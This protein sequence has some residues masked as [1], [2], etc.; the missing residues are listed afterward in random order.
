[1]DEFYMNI[2]IECAKNGI[3]RVQANPLIG[4]VIVKDNK[5]I[6]KD[7]YENTDKIN[8]IEK[9]ILNNNI[10]DMQLNKSTIYITYPDF[11]EDTI[12]YIETKNFSRIVSGTLNPEV[13]LMS[14]KVAKICGLGLQVKVGILENECNNLNEIYNNQFINNRPFVHVKWC[15]T[16]DGKAASYIGNNLDITT[17]KCYAYSHE[18]RNK[19]TAVMVGINTILRDDPTLVC[20]HPGG[21]NS[22]RIIVDSKLR[23]QMDCNVL[24]DAYNTPTFIAVTHNYDK[25]KA[26]ILQTRGVR[27]II[28]EEI[29]GKI[30]L[31][32]L[33]VKLSELNIDSVLIEGG[34]NLIFSAVEDGIVDKVSVFIGAK[35][36]GGK[37]SLSPVTGN[38]IDFMKSGIPL[39]DI[40]IKQFGTDILIEGYI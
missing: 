35:I 36:I 12:K 9:V 29:N 19:Y 38:G 28:C 7:F 33:M 25:V 3:G 32:N 22:Y 6:G 10:I 39:N 11:K 34:G 8:L 16:L 17:N 26:K 20:K 30:D 4:I 21:R 24:N 37:N 18:L 13:V 1:M 2:A 23:I 27:F 14:S 5:L 40:S 15:M 31:V